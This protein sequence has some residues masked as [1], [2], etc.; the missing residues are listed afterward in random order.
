MS[1][2][3]DLESSLLLKIQHVYIDFLQYSGRVAL[4]AARQVQSSIEAE[5]LLVHANRAARKL[6]RQGLRWA[7]AFASLVRGGIASTRG[8][9]SM[10]VARLREAIDGLDEVGLFLYAAAARR[11]A[12]PVDRRRRGT[13]PDRPLR[14]LDGRARHPRPREDGPGVRLGVSGVIDPATHEAAREVCVERQ[15]C[16]SGPIDLSWI[17]VEVEQRKPHSLIEGRGPGMER[18]GCAQP[19]TGNGNR[20]GPRSLDEIA[21]SHAAVSGTGRGRRFNT[22]QLN[23]AYAMLL[24]AQFQGFCR[25]LHSECVDHLVGAIPS[26]SAIRPL[27]R[28][29]FTRDRKLDRGNAQPGSLGADFGRFGID[30]GEEFES[31][32]AQNAA[33]MKLLEGLNHWRNAIAHQ[34][35][36]DLK[37][38]GG[39]TILRLERVRRWRGACKRLALAT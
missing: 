28:I 1:T 34:D 18:Q 5:P 31:N 25:D 38:L 24:A 7:R 37:K 13:S 19:H 11:Q 8:D 32:D 35:F 3:P 23:Q 30:L 39:T 22:Q 14:R 9:E 20:R 16:R 6:D 17:L 4:A 26:P 33:R 15:T 27:V 36:T 10:A 2:L 12:R 29:E 21:Q